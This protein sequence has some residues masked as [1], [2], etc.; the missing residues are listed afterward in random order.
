MAQRY[1]G[2]LTK[3]SLLVSNRIVQVVI[4][5]LPSSAGVDIAAELGPNVVFAP[6]DVT[7]EDQVTLALDLA[8]SSFGMDLFRF[9]DFA[10]EFTHHTGS[11]VNV[12]ISCAGIGV[13]QRVLHP[14]KGPHPLDAF[15]R[16]LQ[17]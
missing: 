16:V 17:V 12:A 11:D 4:L 10:I 13:A 2:C 8:K 15:A 3:C 6:A 7:S 9:Y 14:K 5:D 1:W